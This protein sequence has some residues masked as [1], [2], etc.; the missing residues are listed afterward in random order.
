MDSA[1][2]KN[3]YGKDMA[4]FFEIGNMRGFE[5]ETARLETTEECLYFSTRTI[6]VQCHF[7]V[8]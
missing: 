3:H 7:R 2:G 6:E 4:Q 1:E 8:E 5:I